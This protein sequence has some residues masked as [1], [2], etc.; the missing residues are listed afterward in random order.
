MRLGACQLS[1]DKLI[2]RRRLRSAANQ[3]PAA[4]AVD[5]Q[6]KETDGWTPDRY[7][8]PAPHTMRRAL[9]NLECSRRR[10]QRIVCERTPLRQSH[11]PDHAPFRDDLSSADW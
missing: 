5:R 6:D 3:P 1:I 2:C 11:D 4:A 8:D 7:I 9:I 10:M